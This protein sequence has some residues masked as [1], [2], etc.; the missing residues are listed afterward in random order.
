MS[1]DVRALSCY[2]PRRGTSRL[3]LG[4]AAA[5]GLA[6][7]AGLLFQPQRAFRALLTG[8]M[9]VLGVAI[10]AAFLVAFQHVS[11]AGWSVVIRRVPEALAQ[12]VP[13]AGAFLVVC[14]L[15]MGVLYPWVGSAPAHVWHAWLNEP[16]FVVRAAA[17][18]AVFLGV[19]RWMTRPSYA[20]DEDGDLAHTARSRVRSGL[21]IAVLAVTFSGAVFDVVLSLQPGWASTML[22]VYHWSG[23]IVSA[24]AVTTL[25]VIHLRR[26]GP[27]RQVVNDSHLLDLGR[28]LFGFT[29]FWAYI[30]FS[31]YMLIWYGNLPEETSYFMGRT[32]PGWMT[33]FLC[34]VAINWAIPFCV[35][36]PRPAKRSEGVLVKVCL[37]LLVGR[38]L[39]LYL[40][41]SQPVLTDGPAFGIFEVGP[42]LVALAL[43]LLC[44][45]RTFG[46]RAPVP[47]RDPF[48]Q[49][50]LH[51]HIS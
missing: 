27:L 1:D 13:I 41:I 2:A 32:S 16:F 31:Q 29:T 21:A 8:E 51:H 47:E 24:L 37:L 46:Q 10:G 23:A 18:F 26:E 28:L 30:W 50:S 20:Q 39:D 43:G 14:L 38:W 22:A 40:E 19:I 33:L 15:G 6:F 36:L 48:L 17:Y 44:F 5:G 34:N 4:I 3:L 25:L 49:E 7:V 42:V 45:Y 9:Y 12:T 11:Q 35:L